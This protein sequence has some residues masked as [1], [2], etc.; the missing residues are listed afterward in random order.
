ICH[1]LARMM[2]S[3]F[4]INH[5]Y[6]CIS[7]KRIENWILPLLL[8]ILQRSKCSYANRN[9]VPFEDTHKLSEMLGLVAVHHG[10][11]TIFKRPSSPARFKY[12]RVATEFVDS[13]LH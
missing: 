9:A 5:R 11:F 1:S 6:A 8:P 13:H 7:G 2:H 3:R 12:N 10:A 4:E